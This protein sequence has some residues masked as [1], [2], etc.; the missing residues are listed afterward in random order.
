MWL[1]LLVFLITLVVMGY[2]ISTVAVRLLPKRP[3]ASSPPR[4]DY[5]VRRCD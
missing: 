3:E 4:T 2:L 1:F 5:K